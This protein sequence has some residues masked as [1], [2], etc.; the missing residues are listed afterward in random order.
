MFGKAQ[1][2][3][4]GTSRGTIDFY[5]ASTMWLSRQTY[6]G[7]SAGTHHVVIAVLAAK[8]PASSGTSVVVDTITLR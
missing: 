6:S 8:N 7:L 4:D 5:S 3:I 1:I 2:S